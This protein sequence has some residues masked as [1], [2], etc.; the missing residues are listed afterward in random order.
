MDISL[1][2]V[3]YTSFVLVALLS[4]SSL[5]RLCTAPW[6]VNSS[7]L[8]ALYEAEDGVAT[9]EAMARFST[10]RQF[11]II[12]FAAPVGIAA[13][14]G[15]A[16]WATVLRDLFSDLTIVQLWLLFTSWVRV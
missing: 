16:V 14:F 8:P 6:R 7:S 13:S 1:A 9:E 12:F 15:L 5:W 3:T 10:K 2:R 11:L 4:F